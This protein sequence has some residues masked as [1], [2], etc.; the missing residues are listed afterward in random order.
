M[1]EQKI[2]IN[3]GV[4]N[5][6]D[7]P[8]VPFI[9]GDGT[10]VDIWPAAKNV[11]DSAVAKAYNGAKSIQWKEV[12]AGEKAFNET[13]EWMPAA[14][15]EA[16][17]EY[18][19]GIKGPLTTPVGG[20]IRSL[21]VA[22]RQELDLYA[23]VR[24][25]RWFQGTPSPVKEP[26]LCDMVIFRENTEDIYA[27]IEFEK[28]T[29]DAAKFA[30]LLKE[31]FP[32][33]FK[34]VRFPDSAG[35]G[36]KPV[37]EE[38]THRLVKGAIDYAF[39]Q[40]RDSVTLVHKG[41]IMKFTEGAFKSW[42]YELAKDQYGAQDYEGGP[43]QVIEK[44]GHRVIIKDV[45]ADAFLQQIL[46]RPAEYSVIATL[47]L[48]GDYVSDALAAMVGGIGIAPG[49]NINYKTGTA[50]FEA[51]HGTAPKYAGQDKVN[52]GSVIL[53]GAMMLEYFGWQE[54]ADLIYSGLEKAIASK[55]VTYDFERLMDG[56]TLLKCSEF[57][58]EIVKNM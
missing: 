22:L 34:K 29:E 6:P 58:E 30:N 47:N 28:G 43:W 42:G 18:L 20:G 50:I 1:S 8:T 45:I 26:G 31:N 32:T 39:D 51:T 37:S 36:I 46:L 57:G 27:G 24:P 56:A 15:L 7:N 3:N 10:G 40:K 48:N 52:P 12:L 33:R 38:G 49:A 21:N 11:L 5:V 25:V 23:C 13:G 2:T 53:S 17:R 55:R 44:D 14:T 9:E 4:L 41:N 35:Y 19:V 54:A 16:F